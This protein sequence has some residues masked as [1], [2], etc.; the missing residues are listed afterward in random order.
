MFSTK[1]IPNK[2]YKLISVGA[3]KKPNEWVY[4]IID[5]LSYGTFQTIIQRRNINVNNNEDYIDTVILQRY[6]D[7]LNYAD[8]AYLEEINSYVQPIN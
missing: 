6:V 8:I 5:T 3:S 2:R 7:E 4:E 1:N